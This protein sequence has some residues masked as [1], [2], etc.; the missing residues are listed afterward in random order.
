MP[1]SYEALFKLATMAYKL[2]LRDVLVKAIEDPDSDWD[3]TVLRI[4]D[5]IFNA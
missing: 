1:M 4:V 2:I 5:S 3:D